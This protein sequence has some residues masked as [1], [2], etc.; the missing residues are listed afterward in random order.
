[1]NDVLKTTEKNAL[2]ILGDVSVLLLKQGST[3]FIRPTVVGLVSNSIPEYLGSMF[4][5]VTESWTI[6][7]TGIG[8][9][10]L[11]RCAVTVLL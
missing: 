11:Q 6:K 5:D 7:M 4:G 1:M 2:G 10:R 8:L 3:C 9:I